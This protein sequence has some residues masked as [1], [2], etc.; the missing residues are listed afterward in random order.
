MANYTIQ[1]DSIRL[2]PV[3]NGYILSW[4]CCYSVGQGTYDR[5]NSYQEEKEV[6]KRS[7]GA[8]ALKRMDELYMSS[9]EEIN[10]DDE[11]E[12]EG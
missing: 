3:E 9:G 5:M 11:S 4:M 12:N 6:Y 7:E 8:K 10:E 2:Q 1:S